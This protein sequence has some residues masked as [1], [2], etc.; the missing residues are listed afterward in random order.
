MISVYTALNQ[1]VPQTK[2]SDPEL[3]DEHGGCKK[4]LQQSSVTLSALSKILKLLR[5]SV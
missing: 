3:K 5:A 1:V 2:L 4:S